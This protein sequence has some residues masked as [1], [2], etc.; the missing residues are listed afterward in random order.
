M[1][2]DLAHAFVVTAAV[3]AS[4][5][6]R[7]LLGRIYDGREVAQNVLGRN[8]LACST[9]T[10]QLGRSLPTPSPFA[11]DNNGLISGTSR[12]DTSVAATPSH[13]IERFFSDG[14]QVRLQVAF[15]LS[16]VCLQYVISIFQVS[17]DGQMGA[18]TEVR[19]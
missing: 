3:Q 6:G 13:E 19:D 18:Y 16:G 15:P 10:G 4:A 11:A 7:G 5:L 2:L 14:E 12:I 9:E 8:S 1:T 17:C